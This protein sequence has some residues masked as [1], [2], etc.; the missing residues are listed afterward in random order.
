METGQA[1][2]LMKSGRPGVYVLVVPESLAG[3]DRRLRDNRLME[4]ADLQA[5]LRDAR[6]QMGEVGEWERVVVNGSSLDR[7]FQDLKEVW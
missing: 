1:R 6:M 2:E 5:V 3:L 7:A 4:E